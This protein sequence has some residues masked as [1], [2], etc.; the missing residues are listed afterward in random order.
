KKKKG[1]IDNEISR[2]AYIYVVRNHCLPAQLVPGVAP[3]ERF[4]PLLRAA[5]DGQKRC[6]TMAVDVA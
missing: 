4:R 1:V 5:H 3:T 2:G 6:T